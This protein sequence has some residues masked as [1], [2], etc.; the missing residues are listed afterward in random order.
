M[1]RPYL[2]VAEGDKRGRGLKEWAVFSNS[3][4]SI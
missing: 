1:N 4:Y 3:I 2:E